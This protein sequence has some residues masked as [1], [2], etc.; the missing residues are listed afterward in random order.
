ML[1]RG[2]I[3]RLEKKSKQRKKQDRAACIRAVLDQYLA[4]NPGRAINDAYFTC[5]GIKRELE[6][7]LRLVFAPDTEVVDRLFRDRDGLE[8]LYSTMRNAIAHG[9]FDTLDERE[10]E[11]VRGRLYEAETIAQRYVVAVL[12]KA[13]GAPPLSRRVSGTINLALSDAVHSQWPADR[14]TKPTHM[15]AL[16]T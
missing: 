16:Y 11:R 2:V 13:L 7:H 6:A 3:L 5:L 14:Y 4:S 8:A 10:R 15:A 12:G 1:W 9:S